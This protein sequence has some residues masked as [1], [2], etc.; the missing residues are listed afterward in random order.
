MVNPPEVLKESHLAKATRVRRRAL[1]PFARRVHY[2][3]S[4]LSSERVT[5]TKRETRLNDPAN[6]IAVADVGDV[7]NS[8][9]HINLG[10]FD[11]ARFVIGGVSATSDETRRDGFGFR[12]PISSGGNGS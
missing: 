10:M 8:L 4:V 7:G 2:L 5:P 11:A 12:H 1:S 9:T 3:G 6:A